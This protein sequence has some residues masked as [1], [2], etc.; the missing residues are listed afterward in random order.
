LKTSDF[1][2]NLPKELIALRP[3]EK[4]EHSRLLVLHRD[5]AIE[6][7]TFPDIAGYLESGD[8]L[9]V[10]NTKVFPAR[11]ICDTDDSGKIDILLVG[12]SS[13]AGWWEIL[14]RGRFDGIVNIG[15]DI[16]A[17]VRTE[18][19]R[20]S[21]KFL[22]F[23][24]IGSHEVY[25]VLWRYGYMPLP[26]Y[27]KRFPDDDDRERYQTVYAE[28]QGSIAAP[29]AGL[30]F[31]KGLLDK[32]RDKGADIR[33]LTLHVGPGTFKPIRAEL[34]KDHRMDPEYF[35]MQASLTEKIKEAKRSGKRVITVGTTTTRALEGYFSGQWSAVSVE[36][37]RS[38]SSNSLIRGSTDVFIYPGYKFKAV[39]SLITNFHL[40]CST[41]LMFVSAF[42]GF[43]K[44]SKAYEE[45][46]AA[47][48][49]FFSYGDAM[50]I[51]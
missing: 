10:N 13:E 16:K 23:L 15:D 3:S 20:G 40:P 18:K 1:D 14:L 49:R 28:N 21:K 27:I 42:R 9:I 50:L 46:I 39:D 32:I 41:P 25:D 47:G 5:G 12:E 33:T 6:H 34:L 22:R 35:E 4:R 36:K 30:H 24:D 44:I 43:D 31:T 45:A 7:K 2:F 38:N 19:G 51:L 17:E 48:Y 8:L 26:P 29:T 11:L 37:N